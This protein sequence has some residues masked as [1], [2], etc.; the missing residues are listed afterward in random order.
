[1]TISAL[2]AQFATD[3]QLTT[4][5]GWSEQRNRRSHGLLYRRSHGHSFRLAVRPQAAPKPRTV[6]VREVGGSNPL[7]LIDGQSLGASYRVALGAYQLVSRPPSAGVTRSPRPRAETRDPRSKPYTLTLSSRGNPIAEREH[8]VAC[9]APPPKNQSLSKR[10]S[11][12]RSS[13]EK[14]D[15]F[16]SQSPVLASLASLG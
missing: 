9:P 16:L 5:P 4:A 2:S 10:R 1:M 15:R 12:E 7:A 13:S 11:Q 14:P 6:R 8:A 3:F